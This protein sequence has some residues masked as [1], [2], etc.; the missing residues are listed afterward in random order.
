MIFPQPLTP[1]GV[2]HIATHKYVGGKYTPLDNVLNPFWF[3]ATEHVPM[4]MAPNLITM[5]GLMCNV[6]AF[7]LFWTL[8]PSFGSD[9]EPWVFYFCALMG[10]LYQTLDAMDGKQARR[11]GSSTPL[12]QLF[13]HGCDCLNINGM[14][15]AGA[16]CL[17]LG[18]TWWTMMVLVTLYIAFFVAQW[19]EMYT[20]QL[21]TALFVGPIGWGVTEMQYLLMAVCCVTG[22]YGGALFQQ[23]S[24]Y[25][26]S[27][28]AIVGPWVAEGRTL[29]HLVALGMSLF[30]LAAATM[31][32]C[33]TVPTLLRQG[34]TS[35]L[36]RALLQLTP[37][38]SVAASAL[39]MPAWAVNVHAKFLVLAT[40][41]LM[42]HL[43]NKMITFSMAK[44]SF[45]VAQPAVVPHIAVCFA[46]RNMA[47]ADARA[48][49]LAMGLALFAGFTWIRW[50][51]GAIQQI[52]ARL[53]IQVFTIT[54]KKVE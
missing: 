46:L 43:T 47:P 18:P 19:Q 28:L 37:I 24:P 2:E 52:C 10:W 6:A 11:T 8:S 17:A 50:V 13:D 48:A 31:A 5:L 49:P 32:I 41:L 44:Q 22:W 4:W 23:P 14:H 7:I 15:A 33:Q 26:L 35:A 38:L 12:G 21:Q 3:W 36:G 42:A 34:G 40:G 54:P 25:S 20:G 16:S 27:N 30:S 39:A 9:V 1:D 45:P 29:G 53:S 51:V